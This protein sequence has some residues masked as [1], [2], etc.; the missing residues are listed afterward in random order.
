MSGLLIVIVAVVT[1]VIGILAVRVIRGTDDFLLASRTISPG[2]NGAAVAGEYLS[3]ASFLGIAGLVLRDGISMLW[4][5]VGFAAGFVTL[6]IWVAG[7]LR[8]SGAFTVGDFAETRFGSPALRRI[9]GT[10]VLLICWAYLVPQLRGAGSALHSSSGM[11]Y[12]AGV[13]IAGAIATGVVVAGGM[14]STTYVQAFQYAVK[15]LF[16]AI[17]A[18]M[19]VLLI[20]SGLRA[21]ALHP[22]RG[23]YF[24]KTTTVHFTDPAVMRTIAPV[25]VGTDAGVEEWIPGPHPVAGGA[26]ISFPAGSAVPT[27]DAAPP[28]GGDAWRSTLLNSSGGAHPLF[29]TL[30]LLLAI[31]LGTM[32]LPHVL[33]RFHTSPNG[34]SARR[35]AVV[36]VALLGAFYLFPGVYGLLGRVAAPQLYLTGDTDEVV[37]AIPHAVLGG[38]WAGVLSALV[39]AGAYAA[40]LSVSAGLLLALAAGASHDLRAG[41]VRGL[42]LTVV[43]AAAVAELLALPAGQIDVS[44]SVGWAFTLAA[45]T[46]TPFLMLSLWWPGLTSTGAA[47]GVALGV[48]ATGG[49]AALSLAGFAGSGWWR[50]A[51]A[52][53]AAWTVPLVFTTMVLI[54]RRG[55]PPDGAEQLV[56][57]LHVPDVSPAQT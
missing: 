26:S 3:L 8:R 35:T 21:D 39:T 24:A 19:L 27:V 31:T 48:A 28:L 46:L 29:E 13:L 57:S 22:E 32:G 41:T 33:L 4:Y 36:T 56:L 55:R 11:P 15:L 5:A 45:A 38:P 49:A 7:P 51:L 37:L 47:A 42:R 6:L 54:S 25:A 9:T 12:W 53:P 20:G 50:V 52:Q 2:L 16:L 1:V 34:R 18:I 17:P 40:F 30:S 10:V 44:V 23:T 43:G 14:R